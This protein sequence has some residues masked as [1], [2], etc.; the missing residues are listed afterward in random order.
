V[1]RPNLPY[2]RLAPLLWVVF[3]VLAFRPAPAG[4]VGGTAGEALLLMSSARSEGLLASVAGG[5]GLNGLASNPASL[6]GQTYRAVSGSYTALLAGASLGQLEAAFPVG[7]MVLAV[8]LGNF[9]A[10]SIDL[11]GDSGAVRKVQIQN[12]IVA[13]GTVAVP[14]VAGLSAAL[15]MKW[16]QSTLAETYQATAQMFD[17]GLMYSLLGGDLAFGGAVRNIGGRLKYYS[18]AMS[19]PVEYSAGSSWTAWHADEAAIMVLGEGAKRVGTPAQYS[20]GIETVFLGSLFLRGG[21]RIENGVSAAS[22]GAGVRF[23]AYG[24]DFAR[25]SQP[26]LPVSSRVSAEVRF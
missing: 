11:M 6:A 24:F 9:D 14:V 1:N 7:P 21:V 18:S 17:A 16:Y 12:D 23:R 4:A 8:Q 5:G 25:V 22:I 3:A 26:G 2:P 10:G 15:T 20:F 13:G 19:V